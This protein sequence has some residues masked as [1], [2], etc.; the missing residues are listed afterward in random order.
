MTAPLSFIHAGLGAATNTP[1]ANTAFPN[2]EPTSW[3]GDMILPD[4]IFGSPLE[5][6]IDRKLASRHALPMDP[7]M[8]AAIKEKTPAPD[9]FHPNAG[10]LDPRRAAKL[11]PGEYAYAREPRKHASGSGWHKGMPTAQFYG[12]DQPPSI[13]VGALRWARRKPLPLAEAAAIAQA[14]APPARTSWSDAIAGQDQSRPGDRSYGDRMLEDP[15]QDI[16]YQGGPDNEGFDDSVI[17]T[18]L[19]RQGLISEGVYTA[20]SY[21]GRM[22]DYEVI[23][24]Y[25]LW[26]RPL[27]KL[28]RRSY[29]FTLLMAALT[30]PWMKAVMHDLGTTK[31]GSRL[32]RLYMDA[33][34]PVCRFLGRFN[35]KKVRLA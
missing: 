34:I 6:K 29:G 28:M 5:R 21:W 3:L 4:R 15:N 16:A 30:K 10:H 1:L 33:G 8:E 11:A 32:G 22:Q 23:A 7:A 17:C 27:V 20:D 24:G 18:E 2:Q 9:L 19:Y 26:A 31:R 25:Q 12:T 35:A 13:A 14:A